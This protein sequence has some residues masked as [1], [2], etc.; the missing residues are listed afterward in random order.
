MRQSVFPSAWPLTSSQAFPVAAPSCCRSNSFFLLLRSSFAKDALAQHSIAKIPIPVFSHP[1]ASPRQ[2]CASLG[3]TTQ[4]SKEKTSASLACKA[5]FLCP[6]AT[7]QPFARMDAALATQPA[8]VRNQTSKFRNPENCPNFFGSGYF[9]VFPGQLLTTLSSELPLRRIR[10]HLSLFPIPLTHSDP[11]NTHLYPGSYTR[12]HRFTHFDSL[13]SRLPVWEQSKIKIL[14]SKIDRH[15]AYS[16]L[17][18]TKI[19][20]SKFDADWLFA[21]PGIMRGE[22]RFHS[23][24]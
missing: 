2:G 15:F 10:G 8:E 6:M 9:R 3:K 5:S 21:I 11:K 24:S 14:N 20:N 16:Y 1:F 19:Q 12:I 17:G 13:C 4:A 23:Q 18:T 22:H 7:P